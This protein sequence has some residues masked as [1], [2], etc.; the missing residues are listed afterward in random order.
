MLRGETAGGGHDEAAEIV[1]LPDR[2]EIEA[3]RRRIAGIAA[4]TPL[5]PLDHGGDQPIYLKLE[6]LQPV[7]SFKIRCG[8]NAVLVMDPAIRSRGVVTASAGNFAQGVGFAARRLGISATAVVPDT[9]AR[10]KLEALRSLGVDIETVPHAAWW[11]ILE[12]PAGEGYVEGFV[13]PVAD[14]AVLAGNATI[15][16]ELLEDL[17]ELATVLVPY[18]GG[19]LATGIAAAIKPARPEARILGVETEA[20][21]PLAAAFARGAPVVVPFEGTT[22]VTGMGSRQVLPRM[23]PLVRRLLS[24]AVCTTLAETAAA[25][26]LLIERHHVVAEG[27]GAAPVAAALAG[28]A[29]PGPIVCIVSGGHLDSVHLSKIL[30]GL[31]P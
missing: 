3:A 25:I 30:Q 29:G 28:A 14:P 19:G 11:R 2:Q 16:L 21:I 15:G 8:A 22:F 9:A 17:P 24:G 1:R 26:R 18:G 31:V 13:H 23:W 5:V 7:G 20:G 4:R 27:A 12:D 6:L 10:S